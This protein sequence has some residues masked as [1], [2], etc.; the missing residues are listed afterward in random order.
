[1]AGAGGIL[2]NST[3]TILESSVMNI[4]KLGVICL[5]ATFFMP[6]TFAEEGHDEEGSPLILSVEDREAAGI[7]V[8]SVSL[9]SLNETLRVPAEVV[10]NAYRSARVTPRIQAQVVARHVQLGDHVEAGQSLVTLS[11]VA[12]SEAQGNLIV[13]D[14][15][16]QRVK[17]LGQKAVGERRYTEAQIARQ[18]AFAKVLAYGMQEAQASELLESGNAA[19]AVGDFDLL[20]PLAGTVL[21][22]NFIVGELIDPG[23]VLFDISDESVLWIEASV[24]PSTLSNIKVGADARVSANGTEWIDGTVIQ[25]HHRL[26]ETTRTQGVRIAVENAADLLHPG[27]FAETEISTG[28]GSMILAV[29]NESLTLIKGTPTVFK[30]GDGGEFHPEF[31]KTGPVIGG[32][33]VI[34][35][36]LEAGDVIAIKGVFHLKSLLLKSSIG[37]E[38]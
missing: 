6:I 22:D 35:A 12:L 25:L 31:V 36:G 38:H 19:S 27:Q 4:Y 13:T 2:M 10:I 29:P 8:D 7:T 1:M 24:T 15:E 17:S 26:N 28:P 9:Q 34:S 3:K 20:S 30:L 11:S 21:Q 23:R 18:Q 14:R 5:I 16:W 37:D 33:V 32:W